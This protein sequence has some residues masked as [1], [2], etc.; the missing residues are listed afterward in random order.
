MILPEVYRE[1]SPLS[2]K[3]CFVVFDRRKTHFTFPVHTHPEY[4]IN[5]VSGGA[6]AQRVIGDSVETIGEKDLV[7]IA[8]HE[9]KHAWMDGDCKSA[10]I[11]E[12][13][14][15][16]HPQLIEPHLS[17]NQFQSLKHL[18]K[19]AE[20]GIAFGPAAIEKIQ[21]LLQ[22]MTMEHDGFYAVMRLFVLLYELSK[23]TDYR[24]LSSGKT[25]EASRNV[26]LLKRLHEYITTHIT[27]TILITDLAAELNMSRST[28]ARFLDAQINMS[29]TDYLLD[30]RVKTAILKLKTG[31]PIPD[32]AYQCGFNSISYFYRVFKK[33]IG[34][35]PAEF[36]DNY[37]KQQLII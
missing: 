30:C 19:Y 26:E 32:A 12:I 18:F 28:F 1:R 35:N 27:E 24:E 31:I 23:C 8:N 37:K 11:H 17:K 33:A 2:D 36:R 21:P 22:V 34:I 29:F 25:T 5:F 13:T 10:N 16:F 6:G 15:Q 7:F 9:L 14:I 20:R 4:E 3:D